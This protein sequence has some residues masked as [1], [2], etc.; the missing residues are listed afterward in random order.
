ML[1]RIDLYI[2]FVCS[3]V[4]HKSVFLFSIKNIVPKLHTVPV[5]GF[6][7]NEQD[8]DAKK[9]YASLVGDV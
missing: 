5:V 7:C 8:S 1:C 2:N 6:M 9:C 3:F 4:F